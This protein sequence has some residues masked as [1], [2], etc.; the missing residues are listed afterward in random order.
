M[1]KTRRR[2]RCRFTKEYGHNDTFYKTDEGYFKDEE[3]Y[4]LYIR[5]KKCR[6]KC[7]EIL[8]DELGYQPHKEVLTSYPKDTVY[9]KPHV[10]LLNKELNRL[11]TIDYWHI[12]L[13]AMYIVKNDIKYAIKNKQF[14]SEY[15]RIRYVT[16]IIENAIP[17]ARKQEEWEKKGKI[18]K[19]LREKNLTSKKEEDNIDLGTKEVERKTKDI[20]RFL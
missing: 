12:I 18:L 13:K 3:T 6:L 14:L 19:E 1:A 8:F 11:H 20:S 2:V 15:A 10:P 9:G 17:K 5:E 7:I 4:Q 16:T